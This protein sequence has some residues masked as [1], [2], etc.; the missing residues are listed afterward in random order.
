MKDGFIKVATATPP[1]KVADCEYN[2]ERIQGIINECKLQGVKCI[3]FPELC[4]TGYTCGDLFLQDTLLY[5]SANALRQLV[6]DSEGSDLLC[7]VG[8]PIV[9]YG[10]LYN[11]AAVFQN[12]ELLGLV[13][14][15][16]IP[17]YSEFYELRHFEPGNEDTVEVSVP[18]FDYTV[19]MGSKLLFACEQMPEI[20]VG[21]EVCEDVWTPI[22]P[23]S[24][25]AMAGAI[26]LANLSASDEITGKDIYRSE[27]IRSQS[28]RLIAAYLYSDAGEGESTTDLVFS[29]HNMIAENGTL[30]AENTRFRNG[31]IISEID[32][33]KL[34][35]ERRRIRSFQVQDPETLNYEV[36]EFEWDFEETRLTR[37][38]DSTPFVPSEK[39]NRDKRC[40]EILQIQSMGLKKRMDHTGCKC[41]VVGISGGLDSTLALLV[42]VNAFDLAGIERRRIKA[43]T[44]PCFGTT[45]RTYQNAVSL[46]KC[47]GVELVE[48]DIKTSVRQHFEDINQDENIHDITYENGQARERTQVLMDLANKSDGMVIGTGDMSELALGWATYNGDHMSMYGVNCS[49]PKTLV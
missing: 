23:S 36:V 49:V 19:P 44:M 34:L 9:K 37:S 32:Y 6:D 33:K 13:P 11:V 26:I 8:L 15:T 45:D 25:H 7:M 48:I 18:G 10:R 20:V 39:A 28:A 12:G 22:P 35:N 14:K 38:I 30:L 43:V 17:N 42:T 1:I 3:V 16:H 31:Y 27:L 24:Y 29:G 21:V 40:N 46:I 2:R 47:L 41:A 4:L 5:E